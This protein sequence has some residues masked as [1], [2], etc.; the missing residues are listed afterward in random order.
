MIIIRKDGFSQKHKNIRN[1]RGPY[2]MMILQVPEVAS[3]EL[4]PG[5]A[6]YMFNMEKEILFGKTEC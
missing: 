5:Q 2:L 4:G 1:F 6:N 3:F